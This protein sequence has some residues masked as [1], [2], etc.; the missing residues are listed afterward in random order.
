QTGRGDAAVVGARRV[1][2]GVAHAQVK[3][4]ADRRRIVA[5]LELFA[6]LALGVARLGFGN[7][8]RSRGRVRRRPAEE[9]G[10]TRTGL[11]GEARRGDKRDPRL[12]AS[13]QALVKMLRSSGLRSTWRMTIV[14]LSPFSIS[15]KRRIS[16]G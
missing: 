11:G 8:R 15:S 6:E 7:G 2:L 9:P 4:P 16:L 12:C 13:G 1:G 10:V 5:G 14:V 3:A